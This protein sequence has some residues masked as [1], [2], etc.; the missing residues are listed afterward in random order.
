MGLI[1]AKADRLAA[2]LAGLDLPR[3]L[4]AARADAA[5]RLAT[6]GLPAKRDE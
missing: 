5:G 6:M 4:D 1:A 3:G 2:R